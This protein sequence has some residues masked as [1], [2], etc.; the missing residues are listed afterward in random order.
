MVRS[1]HV[2]IMTLLSIQRGAPLI[3]LSAPSQDARLVGEERERDREKGRGKGRKV[4]RQAV[5]RLGE[6]MGGRDC[7]LLLG[8]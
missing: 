5:F 2:P 4:G 6:R 3:P 7:V 1:S 8:N